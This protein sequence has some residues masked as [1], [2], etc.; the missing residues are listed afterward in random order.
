MAHSPHRRWKG[1][2]IC[3]PH[4]LRGTGRSAKDPASVRRRLGT[5]RRLR[6]NNLGDQN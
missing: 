6:R 1:C 4:K 5:S 2:R 3:K